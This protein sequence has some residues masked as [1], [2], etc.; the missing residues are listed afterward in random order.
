MHR[1]SGNH[2]KPRILHLFSMDMPK[3]AQNKG[4]EMANVLNLGFSKSPEF[5]S[6]PQDFQN[7]I[8]NAI[9]T[10]QKGQKTVNGNHIEFDSE[11]FGVRPFDINIDSVIEEAMAQ[12][13][14]FAIFAADKNSFSKIDKIK[15]ETLEAMLKDGMERYRALW[16]ALNALPG[17]PTN[18]AGDELGMT[19]WET[20]S[21]NEKQENRNA[22]RHDRLENN[23]YK[24]I[25][26]YKE[27]IDKIT[28]IRKKDGASAL[29][30]GALI[31]ITSPNPNAAAFYRYNDK[32]D[33]ICIIHNT[34]F[35]VSQEEK[36]FEE[37]H[38]NRIDLGGLPNGLKVGT[39]YVDAMEPGKKYK[40]TNPYEIKKVDDNDT[41]KILED[42]NLG[43]AGLILLR[44]SSFDGKKFS[45]KGRIENPNV[46][47]ANT[48]YNF[49]YMNK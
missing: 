4:Q 46:K 2:D 14:D 17:T 39:I 11:N 22:L 27:K 48:K 6:L 21:K 31:P 3:F 32:T 30:N 24:F 37:I 15:S 18:Y 49:S 36:K 10:L 43:N 5:L 25:K 40:V 47:L 42:I 38:V 16:F 45:F 34:N 13:N 20:S 41:N 35:D 8:Y 12:N 23:N 9:K 26:D 1:F 19:G 7:A 28:N 33:A 44:E 29:A